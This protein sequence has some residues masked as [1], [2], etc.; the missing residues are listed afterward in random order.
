MI[1]LLEK[2]K[3]PRFKFPTE[4]EFEPVQ[5][6]NALCFTCP[7]T[8]LQESKE[9]KRKKMPREKI[10]NLLEQFGDLLI[11]NSFKGNAFVNPFRY[12]DPLI[13]K[14]LDLI[15][16]VAKKK[17]FNVRIT[18]NGVSFNEANSELLNNNIKNIDDHINISVIGSTAEK[19]KKYMNVNLDVTFKRLEKVSK[20]FPNLSKLIRVGL[21]DV[22]NTDLEEKEFNELKNKFLSIGIQ[23]YRKKNWRHN[24]IFG[25][26]KTQQENDFIVECSLFKNKLLRRME[27]MVDG[28]VVLC[29]DD[30]DGRKKFGN[31][32]TESLEEIWNGK[33]LEEHKL[34]Y[35][36]H[37]SDK[38]NKMICNSCTRAVWNKRKSKF[39]SGVNTIGKKE[40]TKQ[41][42]INHVGWI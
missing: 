2:I 8:S 27:V 5:L 17:N 3:Y 40:F 37:F 29:D 7:Y 30:A 26:R 18:T 39:Y 28:S 19:I 21:A 36:K 25:D 24:R 14:D 16:D 31:V 6:C 38:K 32:F 20:N 33:L 1:N 41:F 9:Y 42:L 22:E 35:S 10:Q 34:I 23:S 15:F 13:C 11:K 12:S 4:L